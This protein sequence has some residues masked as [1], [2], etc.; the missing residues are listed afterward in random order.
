MSS[1]IDIMYIGVQLYVISKQYQ[2]SKYFFDKK[3]NKSLMGHIAHLIS[4]YQ[5]SYIKL[6]TLER[7]THIEKNEKQ[8]TNT[9]KITSECLHGNII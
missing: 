1:I 8:M 7:Y 9:I 3:S 5:F 2:K 4:F 6:L